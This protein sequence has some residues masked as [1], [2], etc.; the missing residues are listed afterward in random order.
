MAYAIIR[1]KK[2]K[3]MGAVSRSAQHTF[4]MQPTP[5]ADPI[6]TGRNRTVGAKGSEQ[7]LAALVRTLPTK[8]R[9]D[10]VLAIEYLVTASPEAFKRHGGRLDDMGDG[11]FADALK[12]LKTRHGA[13]NVLSATIHLDE[14][15]P[16]MVVY[17]VPM[18]ADRR[19]SCRDFLG[20]PEKLRAMQ[21]SFHAKVGAQRGLER[22]VE[23]SKAKHEAVSAFYSTMTAAGEAPVLKPRDYAA[24]AVGMKT[25]AWLRAEAVASANA[26]G[27]AR[28]ARSKQAVLSRARAVKKA[29][30]LVEDRQREIERRE[31]RLRSREV[32]LDRRSRSIDDLVSQASEAEQKAVVLAAEKFDLEHRLKMLESSLCRGKVWARGE[33]NDPEFTLG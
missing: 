33:H 28:H 4:R 19:P 11:Y 29:A 31:H 24:A 18:T 16:H 13:A 20:G 26:L 6:L 8:R 30:S 1:A 3:T 9:K 27:A 5:N 32:D 2:L 21:T 25:E 7:I 22:G 10:A 17:V 15:T 12:W 14:S 23:G